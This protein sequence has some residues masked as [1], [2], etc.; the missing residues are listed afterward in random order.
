[1][2]DFAH[3]D[4]ETRYR[5]AVL[6]VGQQ[7]LAR[8]VQEAE[9]AISSRAKELQTAPEG[10]LERRAIDHALHGLRVLKSERLEQQNAGGLRPE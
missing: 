7:E 3:T 2:Y 6:D 8:R 1:M 10:H 9:L 4:W 5:E